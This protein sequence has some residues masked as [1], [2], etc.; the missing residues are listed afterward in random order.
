MSIFKLFLKSLNV[1]LH[2]L[3]V[4]DIEKKKLQNFNKFFRAY[5]KHVRKQKNCI[6]HT[7]ISHSSRK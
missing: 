1:I 4:I 3:K 6:L 5:I 2:C 7:D